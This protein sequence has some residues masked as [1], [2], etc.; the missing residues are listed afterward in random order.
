MIH[1]A[2]VHWKSDQWIDVQL[3]YLR[4]YIR[5]PFHVYAWLN[6]V[7]GDHGGKFH[8]VTTE[9][10]EAHPIKLNLLAD[11][12]YFDSDRDKD[13]LVFLDGDAFPIGDAIGFV[14]EKLTNHPLVAVQ[15]RENNGDMQ[16][17][18][19]CCAT[20]VGFW[21]EIHGDWKSGY[22]WPDAQ[23]KPVTDVGGNLLAL[24]E[25]HQVRWYPLVRSNRVDLHPLWFGIYGGIVYH[26]GAAFRGPISR[27]EISAI[28]QQLQQSWRRPIDGLFRRLGKSRFAWRLE[29]F[30]PRQRLIEQATRR[31]QELIQQVYDTIVSDPLFYQAFL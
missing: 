12:I 28:D 27:F 1:I 15:R 20:T 10:A 8:Y 13:L 19:C 18:P 4:Q 31:N 14:R 22:T 16:P 11:L 9:P 30:S 29:R 21:K 5:E 25:Q 23:G 24:L 7:P 26:H 17:H 6:E 2:T 3:R